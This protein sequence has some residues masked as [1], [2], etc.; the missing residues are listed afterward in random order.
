MTG[1]FTG[2][3]GLAGLQLAQN[4]TKTSLP[5]EGAAPVR[6][7]AAVVLLPADTVVG[8]RLIDLTGTPV[9]TVR[10]PC[11]VLFPRVA[12]TVTTVLLRTN[13]FPAIA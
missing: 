2:G 1:S 5:P 12:V 4:W 7:T 6:V 9:V 11:A 8:C 13:P 3:L 10:E